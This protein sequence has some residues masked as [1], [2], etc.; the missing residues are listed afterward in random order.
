MKSKNLAVAALLAL[1][2][3]LA[4]LLLFWQPQPP[5]HT[6]L[7][8]PAVETPPGGDFTVGGFDLATLRGKVV[9]LYFGYMGCPDICPTS[10]SDMGR[11]L[12]SLSPE[13]LAQVQGV[14]VSVDPARDQPPALEKY[15]AYFHPAILGRTGSKEEVDRAVGRYGA[16]Y[17]VVDHHSAGGY[18]VDHTANIYVIT[19][20]GRWVETLPYGTPPEKIAAAARAALNP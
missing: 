13:E 14:F 2:A 17:R 5:E 19:A 4:W 18:Q 6:V 1:A 16:A 15:A 9:L 10:L 11:A 12:K 20:D 8:P 7:T 3:L